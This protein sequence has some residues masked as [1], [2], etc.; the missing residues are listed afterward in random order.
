QPDCRGADVLFQAC[1][2]GGTRDGGHPRLLGQQP[3]EGDLR[4][5]RPFLLRT[6]PQDIYG[7]LIRFA[8][9][10]REAR[11]DVPEVGAH[12]R[13]FLVDRAG[14]E[15]LAEG[16]EWHESDAELLEGWQQLFFRAPP[17]QGVLALDRG[18]LLDGVGAA[19]RAHAG[20][21]HA[22]VLHLALRNQFLDRARHVLDRDVRVD[23]VL[24]IQIDDVGPESFQR[25]LDA[26]LDALWAAVLDLLPAG[27]TSDPELRGDHHLSA[28]RRQR[29]ANEL[30]VGVRTVDF[31]RIEE[32]D[33]AFNGR[34][35][36]RDHRLHVRSHRGRPAADR[37]IVVER[38]L[39]AGDRLVVRDAAAADGATATGN[40]NRGTHRFLRAAA[41]DDGAEGPTTA[42]LTRAMPISVAAPPV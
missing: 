41:L 22:E 25:T 23:T 15:A 13:R 39:R 28:H 9:L 18:D 1:Q 38:R 32:C 40:P 11:H 12:K 3:R 8:S 7:G 17:P 5:C 10:G 20:F 42:Q 37:K 33:A 35:D 36:E 19:D 27:I 16:A 24:I 14:Q 6:S 30:F 4:R 31:G 26:L 2:F 29:F 34:A 21:G